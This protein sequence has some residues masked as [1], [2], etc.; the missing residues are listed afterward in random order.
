MEY[1]YAPPGNISRDSVTIDGEEFKHLV[2]VMR[3]KEGDAIRVV[4]GKGIAYDVTLTIVRRKTA[5]GRIDGMMKGWNESSLKVDVAAGILK[6]PAKFDFLVEKVTELG[7][8][9]IIPMTTERTIP[10]H[11]KVE[12][13]RKLALA[14]MKQCGRS[15]LPTVEELQTLSRVVGTVRSYDRSIVCHEAAGV[16]QTIS[17]LLQKSPLPKDASILLL[18]GPEGGFSDEEFSGCVDAGCVGA[19]LGSRRL[20]TETAA[21]AAA[22]LVL[23]Q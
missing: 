14:A 15:Y 3:R 10:R 16:T 23:Q 5:L 6:N 22:S 13:L 7:V 12:R 18:V 2:H 9:K 1:F 21:I 11:T 8:T 17:Q 19:T 20:R 4:D